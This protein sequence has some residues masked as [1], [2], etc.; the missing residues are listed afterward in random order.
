[1]P[2][3][4]TAHA[5]RDELRQ[6]VVAERVKARELKTQLEVAKVEVNAASQAITDGYAAEDERAVARAREVEQ[7][8]VAKVRDP[9]HRVEGAS[10]RVLRAQQAL[11]EFTR[12]NAK[13]LL[14]EHA[15]GDRELALQLTRAGHELV[16]LHRALVARRAEVD[17]LVA[18]IPGASPR[19]DGPPASHAWERQLKDLE[20]AI[21]EHPEVGPPLPRSL[22]MH[23]RQRQD[24]VHRREQPRRKKRLSASEER[25]L[26]SLV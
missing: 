11:D 21:R 3:K 22:G 1:V 16:Q 26:Q 2:R 24:A 4:P 15:Q 19:T 8:A 20:R 14:D 18:A 13:T 17:A 10:L 12:D 5:T 25:E 9:Q 23:D 6:T 7:Q